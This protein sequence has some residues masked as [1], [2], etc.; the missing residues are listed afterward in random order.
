M[1]VSLKMVDLDRFQ[2][3]TEGN[4]RENKCR[5]GDTFA[6]VFSIAALFFS[7]PLSV[8]GMYKANDDTVS[9]ALML[10][11]AF[12]VNIEALIALTYCCLINPGRN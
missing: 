12:V 3:N 6:K 9:G 5:I 7:L 8:F 1:A 11:A 2:V 4:G 10:S